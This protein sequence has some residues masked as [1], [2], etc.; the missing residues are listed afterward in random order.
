MSKNMRRTRKISV[1][2]SD[3][4]YES[5]RWLCEEQGGAS[6]AKLIRALVADK[7][8]AQES[9][10]GATTFRELEENLERLH[11][12]LLGKSGRQEVGRC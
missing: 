10:D 4:E 6:L 5:L 3:A 8:E 1:R 2:F 7:V 12:W 11:G 9:D